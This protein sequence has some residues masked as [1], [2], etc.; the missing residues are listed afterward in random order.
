ME[1]R[2]GQ[3]LLKEDMFRKMESNEEMMDGNIDA[4]QEKME[5]MIEANSEKCELLQGACFRDGCPPNQN[6]VHS[7]R[8]E[9]QDGCT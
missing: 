6:R 3:E 2:A 4:S 1:M 5:A 9:K 7:R 8:N